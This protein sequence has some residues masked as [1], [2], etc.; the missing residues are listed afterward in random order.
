MKKKF[1]HGAVAAAA[2]V[3]PIGNTAFA[4]D[5]ITIAYFLEWPTPNQ[6]AQIEETYDKE[7]GI[8]VNWKSFGSG[9]DMS[10]AMAS[11]DV[12][13]SYSQGLIPFIVAASKGLPI[14]LVGIAVGYAEADNCV[15]SDKAG[16]DRSSAAAV[17]KSLKG[18]KIAT[19]V[20]NVTHYKLLKTLAYYGVS[21]SDVEIVPVAG[22]ND[23][24]AAFLTDRVDIGCAFGGPLDK[25]K[26]KGSVLM[27]GAEQENIGILTFD[28]IS[29]SD[30]FA[31]NHTD[32]LV[33]FLQVTEDSNN[34]FAAN[35]NKHWDTLAKAAGMSVEGV[36]GYL[37]STGTFSFPTKDEQISSAWLGGTVQKLTNAAAQFFVDQGVMKSALSSYDSVIDDKYLKQVK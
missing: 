13:I 9:N 11:G 21:N 8:K 22:G 35:P 6:V 10:A 37:G 4:L 1:V 20:G 14:S 5:E 28:V 31:K 33:K 7:L 19:P 2:L 17:S 27:T 18:M 32:L 16:L 24:A 36:K 12:Q 23:A 25:M 26:E 29:V 3:M 30:D 15:V 34:D